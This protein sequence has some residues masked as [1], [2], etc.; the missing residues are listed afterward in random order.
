MTTLI[1][2]CYYNQ[3]SI[4][5]GQSEAA[6]Q[7]SG[8]Q[9]DGTK[10]GFDEVITIDLARMPQNVQ[11]IV[12]IMNSYQGGTLADV[13]TA[14][15]TLQQEGK[16]DVCSMSICC[17]HGVTGCGTI[18]M[19]LHRTKGT[20]AYQFSKVSALTEVYFSIIQCIVTF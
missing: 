19:L 15:A 4:F 9:R 7:H 12:L 3:T 16:G 14:R 6:I 17:G 13:E 5:G 18:V 11:A 8:D 2:A 20:W 1:D 10:E